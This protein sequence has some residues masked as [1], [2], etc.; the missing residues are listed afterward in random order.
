MTLMQPVTFFVIRIG[1]RWSVTCSLDGE[2]PSEHPDRRTALLN[3][4]NLALRMWVQRSVASRVMVN[5]DDER[6]H[7]VVEFGQLL[8]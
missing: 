5:E 6:W 1:D 8:G 4:E 3:A 7:I 2:S